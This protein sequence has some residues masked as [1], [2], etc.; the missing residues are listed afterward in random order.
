[1]DTDTPPGL[2][3]HGFSVHP[4]RHPRESP[5]ALSEPE[6]VLGCVLVAVQDKAAVGANRRAHTQALLDALAAPA[7][8]L[9]GVR[10]GDR[11]HPLPG[12]YCLESED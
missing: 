9:R 8:L 1:L 5:Q 10:W 3:P 7:A 11:F 12:A 4:R 2:K 6:H